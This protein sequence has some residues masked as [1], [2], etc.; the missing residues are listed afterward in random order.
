MHSILIDHRRRHQDRN[1]NLQ[2]CGVR[3][4]PTVNQGVHSDL[5]MFIHHKYQREKEMWPI[6]LL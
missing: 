1:I 4:N 5:E 2:C 3:N 6:V